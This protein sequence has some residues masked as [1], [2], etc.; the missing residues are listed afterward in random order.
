MSTDPSPTGSEKEDEDLVF[1]IAHALL[2][3]GRQR[4]NDAA[5]FT[6]QIAAERIVEALRRGYDIRPKGYRNEMAS[7]PP[8]PR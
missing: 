4:T 5:A 8:P 2:Y 1:M 6:A 7:W 3:R